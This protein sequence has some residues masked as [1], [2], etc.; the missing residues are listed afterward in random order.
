M[1]SYI[2]QKC[3]KEG[4]FDPVEIVDR[5]VINGSAPTRPALEGRDR[6]SPT[7]LCIFIKIACDVNG[8]Q[9]K[10]WLERFDHATVMSEQWT[11]IVEE[12]EKRQ[13]ERNRKREEWKKNNKKKK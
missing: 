9:G 11:E 5:M 2:A 4:V 13:E 7:M 8:E 6:L 3:F 12:V 1:S 10:E